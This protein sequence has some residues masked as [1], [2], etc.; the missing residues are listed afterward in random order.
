M[1]KRAIGTSRNQGTRIVEQRQL[2]LAAVVERNLYEFVIREGM[3][4][5][6]TILEQDRELMRG[7]RHQRGAAAARAIKAFAFRCVDPAASSNASST[8]KSCRTKMK[9]SGLCQ[10]EMSG[11]RYAARHVGTRPD[12]EQARIRACGADTPGARAKADAGSCGR[13]FGAEP[14]SNRATLP[15]VPECR[16]DGAR[17]SQT[18]AT[19]QPTDT[20]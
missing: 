8:I 7:P 2:R 20:R 17:F 13:P 5:L 15:K 16:P 18:R 12:H 14:A 4:A 3:K 6:D 1:K 19:E 11:S 9:M 10:V